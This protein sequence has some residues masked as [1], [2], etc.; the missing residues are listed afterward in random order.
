[1][2]GGFLFPQIVL[3]AE[4]LKGTFIGT[5]SFSTNYGAKSAISF[6]PKNTFII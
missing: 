2:I 3:T 6:S 1:M 5:C 4:Y